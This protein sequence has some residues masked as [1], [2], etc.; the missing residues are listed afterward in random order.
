MERQ[1]FDLAAHP[2]RR[3]WLASDL[4]HDGHGALRDERDRHRLGAHAVA[5]DA[6]GGGAA[7][8]GAELQRICL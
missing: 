4:L 6:A 5:R 1:G 7:L 2:V 8:S 3:S